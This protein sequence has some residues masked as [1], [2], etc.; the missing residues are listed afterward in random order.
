MHFDDGH[1]SYT[2]KAFAWEMVMV[3]DLD[4]WLYIG[5]SEATFVMQRDVCKREVKSNWREHEGAARPLRAPRRAGRAGGACVGGHF[6][7]VVTISNYT[8]GNLNHPAGAYAHHSML[9]YDI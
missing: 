8:T 3:S 6:S 1:G 2:S 7:R 9:H 5:E 4:D